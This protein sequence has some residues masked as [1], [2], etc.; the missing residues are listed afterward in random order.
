MLHASAAAETL[1]DTSTA[2]ESMTNSRQHTAASAAP[3]RAPRAHGPE[4]QLHVRTHSQEPACCRRTCKLG[5]GTGCWAC[6][7]SAS[8]APKRPSRRQAT[9]DLDDGRSDDEYGYDEAAGSRLSTP[10]GGP[11][12]APAPHPAPSPGRGV[13]RVPVGDSSAALPPRRLSRFTS[14]GSCSS[15]RPRCFNIDPATLCVQITLALSQLAAEE[16]MG[17]D[18]T[19]SLSSAESD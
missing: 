1:T 19:R 18:L 6:R 12:R 14:F 16:G 11:L 13:R 8:K 5:G 3:G 4:Q 2:D 10:A 17:R 7:G 15:A 9:P